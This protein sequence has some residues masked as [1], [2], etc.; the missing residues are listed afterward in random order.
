MKEIKGNVLI[1]DDDP[2]LAQLVEI[3]LG[4]IGLTAMAVHSAPSLQKLLAQPSPPTIDLILLD[5]VMPDADGVYVFQQ[6]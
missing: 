4:T 3:A 6:L 5:L 2:T 1:I